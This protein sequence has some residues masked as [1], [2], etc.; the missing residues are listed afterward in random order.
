MDSL[1]SDLSTLLQNSGDSG[2]LTLVCSDG[3][4]KVHRI[5][6]ATRSPAFSAMLESDMVE[7]RSGRVEIKDFGKNI[8]EA[9]VQFIYTAKVDENFE[10][11]VELMKIGHKYLI[12]SLVE[13]CG[14]KIAREI[15]KENVL[16]LGVLADIYSAQGLQQTCAKFV[17]TNSKEVLGG[18]DWEK[19]LKD[20]P[21]FLVS[22]LRCLKDEDVVIPTNTLRV[23]RFDKVRGPEYSCSHA[24]IILELSKAAT[25]TSVGMFGTHTAGDEIPVTVEILNAQQEMVFCSKTTY[26]STGCWKTVDIPVNV[27]MAADTEYT[28]H[29]LQTAG[30]MWTYWGIGGKAV[31]HSDQLTVLFKN[32]PKSR[33]GTTVKSGQIPSLC[34]ELS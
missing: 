11:V 4:V 29:M 30:V 19:Q 24:A 14:K 25:L 1:T 2:D 6:L 10:D 27:R 3:E 12:K 5:I 15:S 20:Y 32:S 28:V 13:E 18:D 26:K 33:N 7:R 23:S 34:F 8:V 9:L 31:Y 17:V 22:I 21:M 16:E